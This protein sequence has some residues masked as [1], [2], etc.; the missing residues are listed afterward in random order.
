[1]IDI[2]VQNKTLKL[3]WIPH[4][5]ENTDS[6]WVQCLQANLHFPTEHITSW[7]FKQKRHGKCMGNCINM[8]WYEMFLYWSEV[9]YKDKIPGCS[10]PTVMAQLSC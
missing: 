2:T 10:K 9:I 4:I 3:S 8:V 6:F 1:M 7:Q 5:L